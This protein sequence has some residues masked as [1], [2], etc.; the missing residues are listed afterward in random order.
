MAMRPQQW[1]KNVLLFAPLVLAH[2]VTDQSKLMAALYAF[3]AFSLCAS[4]MYVLND[5]F[6]LKTDRD[7][8]KKCRRPL[9]SGALS[10]GTA[11]FLVV[12]LAVGGTSIA[13][14][15]LPHRFLMALGVYLVV[16][17]LYSAWLKKQIIA[18]V[19]TLAG[20]Y[21]LRIVAGG[22]ATEVE[23][24]EWLMAFSIFIFTSLAFVKR[25]SEFARMS[26][27]GESESTLRRGYRTGDLGL[28]EVM[29]LTT[30]M[31]AVLV[32]ALY[33]NSDRVTTLYD[34]LFPLWMICPLLM[35]WIGRVWILARRREIHEDPLVFAMT[36]LTSWVV[37]I[38]AGALLLFATLNS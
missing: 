15:L 4:C 28:I 20:L 8:P 22:L 38:L 11:I 30:G 17:T 18:D 37:A 12:M 26:A 5:L 32:F 34:N 23:V 2:K 33:I 36:D 25:Y 9:A 6:D 16:T 21:T 27:E 29:G 3:V 10:R 1:I 7:H 13:S 14:G 31:I 19:L 35:Y 24:S